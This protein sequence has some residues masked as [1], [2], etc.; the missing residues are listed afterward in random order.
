MAIVPVVVPARG[1][2]DAF[3]DERQRLYNVHCRVIRVAPWYLSV[4]ALPPVTIFHPF[5]LK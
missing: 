1:A 5:A 4:P 2:L 3:E